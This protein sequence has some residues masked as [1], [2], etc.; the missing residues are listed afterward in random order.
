M[1]FQSGQVS[2][3]TSATQVCTLGSVP[4]NEGILVN[5]SAAAFVGPAGVDHH[6]RVPADRQQ[7][8]DHTDY[9]RQR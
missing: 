9:R 3:G 2:V 1:P 5:A 4:E 6:D 8:A 7:P